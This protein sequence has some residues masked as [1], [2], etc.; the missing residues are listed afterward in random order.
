[1]N[2]IVLV[3]INGRYSHTSLG[4]RYLRANMGPLRDSTTLLEFTIQDDPTAIAE[5]VT[6]AQPEL[7][8]IGVYIWNRTQVER[9]VGIL[10]ATDPNIAIVLGGPEITYDTASPLAKTVTCVMCGEADLSFRDVCEKLLAKE[11]VPNIIPAVQPQLKDIILPYDEYNEDDLANRTIYVET[12]RGCAYACE[13]CISSIEPGVRPFPLEAVL[14]EFG[15]LIDRGARRFKFVDR[16]F[17]LD[18]T[19]A[20]TVLDFFI[21]HWKP[22]MCLHLEMTPDRMSDELR[23]RLLQFSPSA[24]HIEVGIQTF[25]TEVARRVGRN[26]DLDSAARGVHFLVEEAKA[27][28]H[29]DLIAGLPGETPEVFEAG[30]NRLASLHPAEIQVGI[31]KR[32]HGAPIDRHQREWSMHFRNT[33]PYDI[34]ST[35]T[36]DESYIEKIRRFAMHWD[37]LVNRGWFPRTIPLLLENQSSCFATFDQL[38]QKVEQQLGL[39]GFGLV[40]AA[41]VLLAFLTEEQKLPPSQIQQLLREDYLDGDRRITV[42]HFLR[43]TYHL[44]PP[45]VP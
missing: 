12:S 5:K 22:D 43:T 17:N 34:L 42:P 32:L 15:K 36:M 13:Y 26:T 23:E 16:S 38:S 35:S 20:C 25:N 1:M 44:G 24:L 30:F 18:P 11:S 28:V 39:S 8:A 9:L 2:N 29:A 6:Q 41:R 19:H 37:R 14:S 40:A 4:A 10:Q 27:D 31:L 7:I 45:S 33:P 21:E 3:A